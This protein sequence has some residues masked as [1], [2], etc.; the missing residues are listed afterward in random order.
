MKSRKTTAT[1]V[2]L[3]CTIVLLAGCATRTERHEPTVAP[4]AVPNSAAQAR[5]E[6]VAKDVAAKSKR[7]ERAEGK[8]N[9]VK[10]EVAVRSGS[11]GEPVVE[12]KGEASWYG[13]RFHGKKTASGG[14]FDQYALTAAHPTLPLGTRAT[15]TNLD[16]GKSVEVTITDRGPHA[17]GRD[18]DLSKAAADRL[19]IEDGVAPVKIDAVVT[20]R[21]AE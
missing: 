11:G 1:L 8:Q 3:S 6:A 5:A 21:P 20:P 13:R 10:D 14:H 12:Q 9:L 18:I 19:G 17:K 2:T 15:V 16:N 7:T 4:P